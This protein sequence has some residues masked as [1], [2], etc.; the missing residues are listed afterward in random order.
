[1]THPFRTFLRRSTLVA[2]AVVAA[3]GLTAT[4]ASAL[5][6]RTYNQLQNANAHRY[7]MDMKSED[8]AEGARAQL[9]NCTHVAEQQFILVGASGP[10][11]GLQT[12]RSKSAG[13]CLAVAGTTAGSGIIQHTC[14]SG[15]VPNPGGSFTQAENWDLR[16]TGEIV[17]E[18]TGMC[19]DTTADSKGAFLMVWPCNGNIAQ[20]W[21]F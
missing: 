9:W 17:N 21:F 20:R 5:N 4:S 18:L 7:C 6:P 3:V 8:P 12:I 15:P 13:K 2:L 1:M 11:L 14:Y 10:V 16:T 19:L